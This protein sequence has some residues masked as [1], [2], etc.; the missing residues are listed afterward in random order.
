ML[1]QRL[2]CVVHPT[3]T[4]SHR[5]NGLLTLA[6][7]CHAIWDSNYLFAC[8]LFEVQSRI[9][10]TY[11]DNVFLFEAEHDRSHGSVVSRRFL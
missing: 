1:A 8:L 10:R 5:Y 9:F 2:P 3:P 7:R 4:N 11:E 6:Q